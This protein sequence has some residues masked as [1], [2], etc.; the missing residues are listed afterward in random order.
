MDFAPTICTL[1]TIY[2]QQSGSTGSTEIQRANIQPKSKQDFLMLLVVN[3]R[4]H[5]TSS[6]SLR[7]NCGNEKSGSIKLTLGKMYE[8]CK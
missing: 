5:S 2:V 4:S 7:R 1:I 6:R 3:I 8:G